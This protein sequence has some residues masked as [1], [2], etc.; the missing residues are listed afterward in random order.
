MESRSIAQNGRKMRQTLG[1]SLFELT[2]LW[3]IHLHA[4]GEQLGALVG[5]DFG[6]RLL[7]A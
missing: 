1:R 7:F 3:L 4:S 2:L 6:G 5:T